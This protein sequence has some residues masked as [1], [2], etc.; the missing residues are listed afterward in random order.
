[1]H[2]KYISFGIFPT[3]CNVTQFISG[4][5]LCMF[6]VV[7]PLIIRSTHNCIYSI[8]YLLNPYCYLP[9]WWKIWNWFSVVWEL[10][11]SVLVQLPTAP[12]HINTITTPHSN[13]F[14]LF[15]VQLPTEPKQ[16]NI[17]PTPQSNQFK[18][19]LVQLLLH[20]NRSIQFPHHTQTSSYSSTT[21]TRSSNVITSTRYCK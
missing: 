14:Q 18:L 6:R 1:M 9:L 8:W 7:S 4:K 20:Q 3:R 21:G 5:L 16:I 19:F 11:R 12:K 13:Q 17:I 2:R 10:Y 15:L